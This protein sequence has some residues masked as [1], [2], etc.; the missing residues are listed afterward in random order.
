MRNPFKIGSVLQGKNLLTEEHIFSL[1]PK[2][3]GKNENLLALAFLGKNGKGLSS[4]MHESLT[5]L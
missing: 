3:E 2:T 4:N 1:I 5:P